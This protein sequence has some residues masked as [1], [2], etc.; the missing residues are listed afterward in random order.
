MSGDTPVTDGRDPAQV[1]ED[2]VTHALRLA[3]TWPAWDGQP[4]S[5]EDRI[6]TP[7]KAIRRIADHLLDHLAEVEA[8]L[9]GQS[10]VPDHW[11][12]SAITTPAD[13]ATFTPEDVDEA[14]ARLT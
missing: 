9:A 11:H 2:A 13:L 12:A 1:I 6:Y 14:R 5:T 3:Q 7:H 10:P 8:R 4:L